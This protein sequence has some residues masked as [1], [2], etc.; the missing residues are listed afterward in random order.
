MID[1]IRCPGCQRSPSRV[2]ADGDIEECRQPRNAF[3]KRCVWRQQQAVAADP[4]DVVPEDKTE[5]APGP[6]VT[7]EETVSGRSSVEP[8]GPE[9]VPPVEPSGQVAPELQQR[10]A[11]LEED[12]RQAERAA[13]EQRAEAD[14]HRG[15]AQ[16]LQQKIDEMQ[17]AALRLQAE[18]AE[19]RSVAQEQKR[20]VDAT[21]QDSASL[22]ERHSAL[23]AAKLELEKVHQEAVQQIDRLHHAREV[24]EDEKTH[25][26]AVLETTKQD[27]EKALRD[28]ARSVVTIDA[29]AGQHVGTPTGNRGWLMAGMG[30]LAGMVIGVGGSMFVP[31]HRTPSTDPALDALLKQTDTCLDKS[32]WGCVDT[33]SAR[34]LA[35]NPRLPVA[36]VAQREARVAQQQSETAATQTALQQSLRNEQATLTQQTKA[37]LYASAAATPASAVRAA[38]P[39][40]AA[41][42]PQ[43]TDDAVRKA[44]A[45]QQDKL[46]ASLM[47]VA[48]RQRQSSAFDCAEQLARVARTYGPSG[49][50]DGFIGQVVKQRQDV[51]SHVTTQ[52]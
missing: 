4:H 9:I 35:T 34:I 8:V 22:Q 42:D 11:K 23:Q 15:D 14:R 19:Q 38:C 28:K 13:G 25:L 20:A 39:P 37:A 26:L 49:A 41:P 32:D 46:T 10:L 31:S 51:L 50:I 6:A 16:A 3:A 43:A 5:T 45:R 52:K 27:L 2:R 48:E 12:L 7:P 1:E 47:A 21:L 18:S 44:L 30:A 36:L 40:V 33:T 17:L 29:N 24:A